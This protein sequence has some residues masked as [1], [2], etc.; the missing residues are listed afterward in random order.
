MSMSTLNPIRTPRNRI[1]R[2]PDQYLDVNNNPSSSRA[3]YLASSPQV[4]PK[5]DNQTAGFKAEFD[6]LITKGVAR[7]V[8]R[9]QKRSDYLY[10]LQ[11]PTAPPR[12]ATP[13]E[14]VTDSNKRSTCNKGY[15]L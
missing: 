6:I 7:F 10:Y 14:K 8:L 15:E 3:R 4:P 9:A 13:A 11:N 2:H 12:G 1:Y 5:V